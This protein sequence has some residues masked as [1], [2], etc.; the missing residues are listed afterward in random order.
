MHGASL[1]EDG[2]ASAIDGVSRQRRLPNA[3]QPFYLLGIALVVLAYYAAAHLGFAFQFAGPVA[4]IVWLPTGVG[5]ACLYLGGLRFWPGVLAGDLLVNNYS[6][7]P[8]GSAVGQSAGNLLEIVLATVI[9]RRLVPRGS[10]LATLSGLAAIG[11]AIAIGTVA[12]A[13]FGVL[14]LWVG[15][16]VDSGSITSVWRTWWLGDAT[17]ALIVLPLAIA[18]WSRE[19]PAWVR[20]RALEGALLVVAV[21]V[22]GKIGLDTG[23]PLSYIVFPALIWAGLRFGQRGATL[24][25]AIVAGFAVWGTTHYAGPFVYHSITRAVLN[26][27]LYIAVA[28]LSTL[29]LAAVV[30]ERKALSA[31][32]RASR[33]RLV[34]AADIERRRL[35]RDLHDGA[36]QRL[37]ALAAH[38]KL[39]SAQARESPDRSSELFESA[40]GELMVAIE[41]L[42]ALAHGIRPP[43]LERSGLAGAM[44]DVALTSSVPIDLMGVPAVRL[45]EGTETTAYFVALEAIANAQKHSGAARIQ[46]SL[47]LRDGMLDVEVRD[48]GVG[49]AVER[50][51]RGLEGLRDRVEGVGGRFEVES[52]LD[53]G[54]RVLAAIPANP[55]PGTEAPPSPDG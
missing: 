2:A 11:V 18:W 14:S 20:D 32:L 37:L 43:V 25:I 28:A 19:V 8:V 17:G 27:Q 24:A 23:P 34:A 48:D 33:T 41:E 39:S 22:L 1:I 35:E 36:Q 38:L 30:S 5:I 44:H 55:P 26:T 47:G 52:E 6:A 40:Y 12:S 54:T 45:E 29:C 13:T 51:G 4:A 9:L 21:V 15:G 46:V 31:R 49:G 3:L 53:H 10:P 7:L 50:A 42:R 16:V